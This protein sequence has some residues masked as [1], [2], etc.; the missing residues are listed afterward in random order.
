MCVY[1]GFPGFVK[2]ENGGFDYNKFLQNN[3]KAYNLQ[4]QEVNFIGGFNEFLL[5][6]I[7][8]LP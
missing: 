2:V 7:E 6:P 1:S 5:V 3:Y 8:R 4:F